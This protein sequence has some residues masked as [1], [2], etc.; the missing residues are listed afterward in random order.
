MNT[1][2]DKKKRYEDECESAVKASDW[3]NAGRAAARSA[4]VSFLLAERT[5]GAIAGA[6]V[7]AAEGWLQIADTLKTRMSHRPARGEGTSGTGARTEPAAGDDADNEWLVSGVPGITFDDIVGMEPLKQRIRRYMLKVNNPE[8][9]SRW[10]GAR[11]GDGMILYGPP[12]TGKTF[13]AKAV[14]TELDSSFFDV[15]GSNLL[16]K[17]VGESQKNVSRLFDTMSEHERA[18][19]YMDEVDGLLASRGTGSSSVREGVLTEFLQAM[20]G[21]RSNMRSLL[22][23]G[24]TNRPVTIDRAILSRVGAMVYVPL[25]DHA[26][27]LALLERLFLTLPDGY[28]SS[29]DL[30]H[31]AVRFERCSMRD[32]SRFSDVLVDLGICRKVETGEGGI[33]AED[34]E[35]AWGEASPMPMSEHELMKYEK[36]AV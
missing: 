20:D 33:G 23:I 14:A 8:E 25:P 31:L 2:L 16:S 17:W 28:A 27:R 15:K 34:V 21:V 19:L 18:V 30:D 29:V 12:G 9:V 3:H 13:F 11:S 35:Q 10:P 24:A 22:F 26:A 36:L 5:E 32:I 4:E 7:K 1:L 6:H